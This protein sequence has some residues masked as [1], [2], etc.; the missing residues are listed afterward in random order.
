M[1]HITNSNYNYYSKDKRKDRVWAES[2]LIPKAV[3]VNLLC[4]ARGFAA[5]VF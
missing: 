4:S 2:N 5:H 1:L 3:T